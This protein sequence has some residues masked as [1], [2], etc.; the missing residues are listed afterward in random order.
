[1]PFMDIL[2]SGNK[3]QKHSSGSPK[4]SSCFLN[5]IKVSKKLNFAKKSKNSTDI[6]DN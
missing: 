5:I 2:I 4:A 1:M 3:F 6:D